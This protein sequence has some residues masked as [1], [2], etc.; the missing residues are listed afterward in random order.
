MSQRREDYVNVHMDNETE[1]E[2]VGVCDS[3]FH[4][5]LEPIAEPHGRDTSSYKPIL[6]ATSAQDSFKG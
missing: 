4:D 2:N 5:Y 6:G 3:D 1:Y